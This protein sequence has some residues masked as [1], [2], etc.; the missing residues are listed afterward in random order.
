MEGEL[1]ALGLAPGEVGPDVLE[2]LW[3]QA[4]AGG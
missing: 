4:K 2:R 3:T 1:A